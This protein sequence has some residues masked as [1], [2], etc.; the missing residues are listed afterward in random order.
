MNNIELKIKQLDRTQMGDLYL[1]DGS[2]YI[3]SCIKYGAYILIDL[4]DGNRWDDTFKCK[5]EDLTIDNIISIIR[6]NDE[7]RVTEIEY[8]GNK[9]IVVKD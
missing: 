9:T 2:V 6:Q 7:C 8:L 5:D 3:L 4:L 1:I